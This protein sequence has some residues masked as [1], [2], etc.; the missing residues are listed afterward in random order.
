MTHVSFNLFPFLLKLEFGSFFVYFFS[1]T[2][3]ELAFSID[4]EVALDCNRDV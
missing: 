2:D 4:V 1:D 3:V